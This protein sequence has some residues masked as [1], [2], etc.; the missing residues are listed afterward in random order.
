MLS[1]V[2]TRTE[3]HE[4]KG[5]LTEHELTQR[6]PKRNGKS[7]H[8]ITVRRAVQRGE[9]PEFNFK[10]G[11]TKGWCSDALDDPRLAPFVGEVAAT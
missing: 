11:V 5:V 8:V 10:L 9:L 4:M 1:V 6:L 7:R 3:T 2:Q